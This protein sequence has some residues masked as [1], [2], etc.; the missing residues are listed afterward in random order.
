MVKKYALVPGWTGSQADQQLHHISARHLARL[1]GVSMSEC[2]VV[3]DFEGT[4]GLPSGL[5]CLRPR[6]RGDYAQHLARL[7]EEK[8]T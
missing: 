1:Y 3:R 8:E 2:F 6:Y 4:R 5:I 7:K